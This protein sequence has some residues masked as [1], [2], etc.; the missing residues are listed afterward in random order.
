MK[1]YSG[2]SAF[3]FTVLVVSLMFAGG[4]YAFDK[5]VWDDISSSSEKDLLTYD[6]LDNIQS[7][8]ET[9]SLD[10]SEPFAM[11][12]LGVDGE[13]FSSTRTDSIMAAIVDPDNTRISLLSIPRD[14]KVNLSNGA[15]S[16]INAA[17]PTG[18]IDEL[19]YVIKNLF[20]LDIKYYAN[21]NFNGFVD[22]VDV[23]GGVTVE[24]EKD[25]A[26]N[27]RIT[28]TRFTLTKGVQKL[29]G[30]KALNYARFRGDGEGDF[31][32]MRRQQQVI[33]ALL[34]DTADIRNIPKILDVL[35]VVNDN[36][37]SNISYSDLGKLAI[38]MRSISGS[39]IESVK[40]NAYPTMI[41]GVS[42][43][44]ADQEEYERISIELANLL[45]N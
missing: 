13:S 7:I 11:L 36:F 31:G 3:I 44:E 35:D 5:F 41:N 24:V 6:N 21:I 26:F 15:V 19:S 12:L 37:S 32:R 18:G 22:F 23:I 27:D 43:V 34:S 33:K 9:V 29:D 20:G 40:F 14:L 4:V 39:S 30:I 28:R 17:Y 25:L 16:K 8:D 10:S 2:V 42:Y 1:I 45:Y 38:K